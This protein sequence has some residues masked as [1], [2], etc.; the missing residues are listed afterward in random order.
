MKEGSPVVITVGPPTGFGPFTYSFDLNND[1]DFD[2]AGEL[3]NL[4][5]NVANFVPTDGPQQYTV[6]VRI[7][8]SVGLHT[9]Q[10]VIIDATDVAPTVGMGGVPDQIDLD[11][12]E[13]QE[14]STQFTLQGGFSDPS[15]V[16]TQAGIAYDWTITKDGQPFCI[17][18]GPLRPALPRRSSIPR[19]RANISSRSP[20]LIRMVWHKP[21][22]KR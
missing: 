6:R 8:D 1:G 4:R 14:V 17:R 21:P 15:S 20:Q 5:V 10:N 13:E 9:D 19:W 16:D 2:D 3:K 18:P 12:Y 7:S 22:A 11:L